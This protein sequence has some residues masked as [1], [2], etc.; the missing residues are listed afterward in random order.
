MLLL[1]TLYAKNAFNNLRWND[2]LNTLEYAFS[3]PC[4]VLVM[5]SSYLSNRQLVYNTS[6]RRRAKHIKSGASQ[7]FIFG[8]YLWNADYDEIMRVDMPEG[9]FSVGYEDDIAAVITVR[10]TV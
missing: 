7:A 4:Y 1:A 9:T 2:I 3:V 5:I 6:A 10:N 8:P